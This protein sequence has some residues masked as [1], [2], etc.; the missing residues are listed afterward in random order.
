MQR[1]II[2]YRGVSSFFAFV[3]LCGSHNGWV[4]LYLFIWFMVELFIKCLRLVWNRCWKWLEYDKK[5]WFVYEMSKIYENMA[6]ILVSNWIWL[7]TNFNVHGTDIEYGKSEYV[8]HNCR[9]SIY[10]PLFNKSTQNQISRQL[11]RLLEKVLHS[12]YPICFTVLLLVGH[13]FSCEFM[14][15]NLWNNIKNI[16]RF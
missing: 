1:L 14:K 4:D 7:S 5:M 13:M 9:K 8:A 12:K 11:L 10:R 6:L 15:L 2:R 16:Q 3:S